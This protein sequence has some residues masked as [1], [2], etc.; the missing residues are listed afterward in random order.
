MQEVTIKTAI[1]VIQ[2]NLDD[3]RKELPDELGFLRVNL[4]NIE[5][6]LERLADIRDVRHDG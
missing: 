3:I 5:T 6:W 2:A 4:S 1:E